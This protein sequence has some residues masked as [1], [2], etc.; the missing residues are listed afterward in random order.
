LLSGRIA[1][2]RPLVNRGAQANPNKPFGET[3]IPWWNGAGLQDRKRSGE[4]QR[5]V[6]KEIRILR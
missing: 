1:R 3:P 6:K 4:P 5:D 2:T